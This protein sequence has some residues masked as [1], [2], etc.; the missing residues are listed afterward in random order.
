MKLPKVK[1]KKILY[2]TDLSENARLAFAYAISLAN[3]YGASITILHVLSKVPDV[4]SVASAYIGHSK[5]QKIKQS[6]V[7]DAREALIGKKRENVAIR[8]I[9][10]AFTEKETGA[11]NADADG[12]T[13]EIII[14]KGKADE[15]IVDQ[16]IERKCD[17]IVMGS[18]GH[19]AIEEVVVG[20]TARKVIRRSKIP[21]LVIPFSR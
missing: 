11:S 20:S 4:D 18:H 5:W 10:T 9:L 16:A 14:K 19:G 13:D 6:V 7:D 3:V 2:A 8:E 1:I 21:V 17:V 12:I 15:L